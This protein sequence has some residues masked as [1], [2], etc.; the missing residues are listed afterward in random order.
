MRRH[1]LTLS[2]LLAYLV[3]NDGIQTVISQA[4]LYGSEE[5]GAVHRPHWGRWCS[6]SAIS[7][8]EVTGT[9]FSRW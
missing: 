7:S 4:S 3:Y 8:P 2:F 9:R 6:V 5:L 1:P